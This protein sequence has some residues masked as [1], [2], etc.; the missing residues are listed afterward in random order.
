MGI[1]KG[2]FLFLFLLSSGKSPLPST[3]PGEMGAKCLQAP[4]G[5]G[6][7]PNPCVATHLD[8]D[9]FGACWP[10]RVAV[11][12]SKS[13]GCSSV[14]F[15]RDARKATALVSAWGTN[16]SLQPWPEMGAPLESSLNQSP[17]AKTWLSLVS[18][19]FFPRVVSFLCYCQV[20]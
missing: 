12:Q 18:A 17:A 3:C 10:A 1:S 14:V 11:E 5:E 16:G 8:D 9:G 7:S 2:A 19:A 13:C 15:V 4:F 6:R 20:P